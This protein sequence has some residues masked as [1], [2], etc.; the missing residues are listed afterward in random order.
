MIVV[1][2]DGSDIFHMWPLKVLRCLR[3]IPRR[4]NS[5][6]PAPTTRASTATRCG[7][8]HPKDDAYQVRGSAPTDEILRTAREKA[9]AIG[10]TKI[11][12]RAIVG[13]PVEAL[14]DLTKAVDAD[15]SGR[16][17]RVE[18]AHRTPAGSVPSDAARKSKCDVLIVHTSNR[19]Q[20]GSRATQRGRSRAGN[21]QHRRQRRQHLRQRFG[22]HHPEALRCPGDGDVEV[23]ET[24]R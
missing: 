5:S 13:I 11:L 21:L 19:G 16:Q 2:T 1:G 15:L 10:A 8:R 9:K 20:Y 18:F 12:D 3:T 4:E 22:V 14:L 23:V 17:P 7:D 6:S 24:A